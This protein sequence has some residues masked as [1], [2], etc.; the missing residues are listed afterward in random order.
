MRSVNLA[1]KFRLFDEYWSPKI[2]GELNDAYLQRTGLAECRATPGNL[3]VEVLRR[4]DR[5][6]THF[7]FI[8][9]WES[10]EAIRTFAGDDVERAHY[11]PD[12]HEYLVVLEPTVTHYEVLDR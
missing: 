1:A 7:L 11:Y 9:Y 3:G 10:M 4:S 6:E 5:G 2:V 8:S 12:D